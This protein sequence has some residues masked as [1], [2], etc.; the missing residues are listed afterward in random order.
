LL[1]ARAYQQRHVRSMIEAYVEAPRE[2]LSAEPHVTGARV[3]MRLPML[4]DRLDPARRVNEEY[5]V[6]EFSP[7]LCDAVR[8]PVT[9][10]YDSPI[11]AT[12]YSLDVS[13]ALRE[14]DR[15][16]QIF[17]P[18]YATRDWSRFAGVELPVGF[19]ACLQ[20]VA[21]VRDLRATPML[22]NLDLTPDWNQRPLYHTI[23]AWE[24]PSPAASESRVVALP[25]TLVVA[26]STLISPT[27]PLPPV[28]VRARIVHDDPAGR[29]VVAGT[30]DGPRTPLLQLAPEA[31]GPDDR[32]VVEGEVRRGGVTIGLLKGETWADDKNLT[33]DTP[34]KFSV[35]LAPREPASYGALVANAV[36]NSWI[37]RHGSRRVLRIAGLFRT[38]TDVRI[39]KA[40][41][42]S[43]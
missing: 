29:W 30:P 3:L 26:R 32:F 31:R 6:A 43:R 4:W 7:R 16:T 28:Q 27:D 11:D 42:A 37:V 39:S 34:G 19:E 20:Q 9:F 17:F 35:V 24:A 41:W 38:F 25:P 15:P 2:T 22:L 14:H 1:V 12:D 40:G 23:S 8:L 18:A 21:R 33:I 13:V 10:R 36:D 5:I